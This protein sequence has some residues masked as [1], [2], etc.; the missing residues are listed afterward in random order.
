[1]PRRALAVRHVLFEDLGILEPLLVAR[2]YEVSYADAGIDAVSVASALAPELLVVLGGPIGVGDVDRYP[3]LRDEIA[4]IAARLDAG[5]PTLG[6]CL[7]AQLM[8]AALGADVAPTGRL[9]LGFAPL[10]LTS[11]G[12]D[13]VLADLDGVPVLHW[14]GDQFDIPAGAVRLAET[15]GFPNQAFA[16]GAS[17]LA[18]QF[19]PEVDPT[20]LE[21]WLIGHAGELTEAGVDPR[22]LRADAREHGDALTAAGRRVFERWL[23]GTDALEGL[24]GP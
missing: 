9:E 5:L 7:G 13:S 15:P 20:L 17:A 22:D 21:R 2:G 8:A 6:I 4:A 14:H 24:E 3:V 23:D 19:H 10:T 1:M 12:R 11:E 16:V 18:L